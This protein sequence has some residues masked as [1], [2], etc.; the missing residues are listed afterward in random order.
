MVDYDAASRLYRVGLRVF[1]IG[2]TALEQ[3]GFG[4]RLTGAMEVWHAVATR[5]SRWGC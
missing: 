1:E 2:A 4:A 3:S 5:A